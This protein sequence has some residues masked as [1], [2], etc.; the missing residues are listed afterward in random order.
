MNRRVVDM[1]AAVAQ[2]CSTPSITRNISICTDVIRRS[3][4]SGAKVRLIYFLID[5]IICPSHL[6]TRHNTIRLQIV[7]LPEASDFIAP[8]PHVLSLSTR[9]EESTFV[10]AIR[11]EAQNSGIWIGVG[12]HEVVSVQSVLV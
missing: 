5:S 9:L 1:L 4:A 11:D 6:C 10:Q 2:I 8:T 3:A 7:Y 12:I